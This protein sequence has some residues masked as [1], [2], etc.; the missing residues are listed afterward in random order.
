[1]PERSFASPNFIPDTHSRHLAGG[2]L[3]ARAV[4]LASDR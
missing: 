3:V 2:R 4:D 1:L